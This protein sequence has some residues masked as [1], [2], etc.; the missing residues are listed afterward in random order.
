MQPS[1]MYVSSEACIINADTHLQT[2]TWMKA[3]KKIFLLLLTM[4]VSFAV[5]LP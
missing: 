4:I 3:E 2:S 5:T 1:H